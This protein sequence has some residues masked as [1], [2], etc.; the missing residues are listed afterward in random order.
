M[1]A[2]CQGQQGTL[3]GLSL[4]RIDTECL[5]LAVHT[6][7]PTRCVGQPLPLAS[8]VVHYWPAPCA[9]L[10]LLWHARVGGVSTHRTVVCLDLL[11]HKNCV[12]PTPIV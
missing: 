9:D 11:H 12:S 1:A 4:W 6:K 2:T 7:R 3:E 5:Q 8:L 10:W